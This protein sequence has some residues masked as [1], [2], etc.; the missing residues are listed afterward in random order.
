MSLRKII[1][2]GPIFNDSLKINAFTT[3]SYF[4]RKDEGAKQ[5]CIYRGYIGGSFVFRNI[6]KIKIFHI[7]AL[8]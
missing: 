4:G 5:K 6:A 7:A 2:P 8:S 1:L 3:A